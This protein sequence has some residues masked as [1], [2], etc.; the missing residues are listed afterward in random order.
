[1]PREVRF[2]YQTSLYSFW[3]H[4]IHKELSVI[5]LNFNDTST[6]RTHFCYK[7]SLFCHAGSHFQDQ[8]CQTKPWVLLYASIPTSEQIVLH[9]QGK[10]ESQISWSLLEDHIYVNPKWLVIYPVMALLF[11]HCVGLLVDINTASIFMMTVMCRERCDRYC[12]RVSFRASAP[13]I[14]VILNFTISWF[15]LA[16]Y[17][18]R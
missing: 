10:H 14:T 5:S 3:E 17:K 8:S 4:H 11:W 12:R 13:F 18:V 6:F 15:L 7:H 2:S 9:N 1:M 16:Q